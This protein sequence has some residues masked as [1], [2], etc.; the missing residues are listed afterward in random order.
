[1]LPEQQ[2]EIQ[3]AADEIIAWSTAQ[4]LEQESELVEFFK[5]EGLDV[6][7]PDVD[8]FR[9]HAQQMYL[10]SEFAADWPE[11]MLDRINAM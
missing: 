8:A 6:Y 4:H 3:A 5:Q 1:M 11:G 10:E 2:A 7:T 9:Q